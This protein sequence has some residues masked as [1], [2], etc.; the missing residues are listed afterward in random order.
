MVALQGREHW[1]E[2]RQ[3]SDAIEQDGSGKAVG[4]TVAE[5]E[6]F[7]TLTAQTYLD[8]NLKPVTDAKNPTL[9]YWTQVAE[10]SLASLMKAGKL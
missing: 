3:R 10:D 6:I 4:K 2:H 1:P 5:E 9:L 8:N 7:C